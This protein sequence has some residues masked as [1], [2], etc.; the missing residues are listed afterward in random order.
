[1]QA[2]QFTAI[3]S[4]SCEFLFRFS[5]LIRHT[6]CNTTCLMELLLNTSYLPVN[7][8]SFKVHPPL[9]N[10]AS[11]GRKSLFLPSTITS[12]G[13]K[14]WDWTSSTSGKQSMSIQWKVLFHKKEKAKHFKSELQADITTVINAVV[15]LFQIW[16]SCK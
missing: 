3:S 9:N 1:M 15:Y 13:T 8:A 10:M 16:I 4:C 6:G 5:F 2:C 12:P 14:D 7:I 11:H